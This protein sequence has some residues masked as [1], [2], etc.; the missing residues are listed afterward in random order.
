MTESDIRRIMVALGKI[1]VS[2]EALRSENLLG[3]REHEDFESRIRELEHEK[4]VD[5]ID[6]E[7]RLRG[8]ERVR[9]ILYGA[10]TALGAVGGSV[11]T[12]LLT[13]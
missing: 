11:L 6:V 12:E 4:K 2:V 1:E 10:A 5:P 9:W 8:L 3:Q 7:A 13:K